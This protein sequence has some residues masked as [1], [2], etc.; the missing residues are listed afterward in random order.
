MIK[1]NGNLRNEIQER[2]W[3]GIVELSLQYQHDKLNQ[4]LK[5]SKGKTKTWEENLELTFFKKTEM[6]ICQG[7]DFGMFYGI[8]WVAL[9]SYVYRVC[10]WQVQPVLQLSAT[11][12]PRSAGKLTFWEV[13]TALF[14]ALRITMI[15]WEQAVHPDPFPSLSLS[16]CTCSKAEVR[17][18]SVKSDYLCLPEA[19]AVCYRCWW[20]VRC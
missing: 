13:L 10:S 4:Q 11:L 19:E 15:F 20:G 7:P 1:E 2:N 6:V 18:G 17:P 12:S 8:G 9:T 5:E 16:D 14:N 3:I